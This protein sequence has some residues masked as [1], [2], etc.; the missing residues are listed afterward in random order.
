L[1]I[2][3]SFDFLPDALNSIYSVRSVIGI[4]YCQPMQAT[5]QSG[6]AAICFKLKRRV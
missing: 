2:G 6:A 3:K 4:H 1:F 5:L